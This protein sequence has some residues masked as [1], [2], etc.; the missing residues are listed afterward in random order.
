MRSR[1]TAFALGKVTYL[2]DTVHPDSPHFNADRK[3]WTAELSDTCNSVSFLGL[4]I[5]GSGVD[6]AQQGWVHFRAQLQGSDGVDLS[7][8]ERSTFAKHKNR[9]TYLTGE[10]ETP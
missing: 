2:M 8:A 7:F 10:I 4:V 6:S 9:W 5:L 3:A 1:Y